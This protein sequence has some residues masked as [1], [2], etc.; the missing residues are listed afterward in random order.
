MSIQ[1]GYNTKTSDGTVAQCGL[2]DEVNIGGNVWKYVKASAN[3]TASQ[4]V[5]IQDNG[6]AEPVTTTLANA[7]VVADAGLAQFA[8]A[9]GRYGFVLVGPFGVDTDGTAFTVNAL[10]LCATDVKLYTTATAGAVDD[11]STTLISGLRLASTN[12]AGGTVATAC[13]AVDR[14]GFGKS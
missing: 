3:I 11:S 4:A 5:I 9:S 2:G 8:I 6:E 10:T 13:T 14:L 7:A 12:A 1:A